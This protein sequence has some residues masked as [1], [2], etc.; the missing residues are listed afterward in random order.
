MDYYFSETKKDPEQN[1][2]IV[3]FMLPLQFI[4]EDTFQ[5]FVKVSLTTGRKGIN[6]TS[7][8]VPQ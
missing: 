2:L 6:F 5:K 1:N 7:I 4:E 8:L 3:K